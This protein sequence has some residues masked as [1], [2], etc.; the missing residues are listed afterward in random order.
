MSLL[1]NGPDEVT[2]YAE[3]AAVSTDEY[4]NEIEV[5]SAT[6]VIIR[7]RW[8]TSTAEEASDLGQQEDT[9]YRFISRVFPSGPY[10]QVTFEGDD[11]DV[12][13]R[14]KH[15]R[16]SATTNHFTTFLKRR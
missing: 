16:G 13:A 3:D 2:V 11:Y 1:D 14:P 4:E 5:P 9:V 8:Q 10:G 15:R 6:G 7:G 12:L